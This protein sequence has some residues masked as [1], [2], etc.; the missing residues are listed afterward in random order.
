MAATAAMEGWP[1]ASDEQIDNAIST[2]AGGVDPEQPSKGVD[3]HNAYGA[4]VGFSDL[5]MYDPTGRT[6]EE[7]EAD[8]RYYAGLATDL[9][10]ELSG[11][12]W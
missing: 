9:I 7:A 12:K 4:S 3:L 8:A 1:H 6:L 2:L 10:K 5:L 11:R